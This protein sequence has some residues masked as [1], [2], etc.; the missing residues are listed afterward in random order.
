MGK[1]GVLLYEGTVETDLEGNIVVAPQGKI[2]LSAED[3]KRNQIYRY[4]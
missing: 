3:G 2:E 1:G 4:S